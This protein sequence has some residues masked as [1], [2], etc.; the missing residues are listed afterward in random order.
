VFLVV[1]AMVGAFTLI[2]L[3]AA[4]VRQIN[5]KDRERYEAFLADII[6][7][8]PDPFDSA[9]RVPMQNVPQL[10]NICLWAITQ[11]ENKTPT[12]IPMDD[13]GY[14][15]VPED[16]VE[17]TYKRIFGASPPSHRTVEGSDFDF[18]YDA[19]GKCYRVPM[20]GSLAIYAPRVTGTKKTGSSIE[21]TV[22]YLAY[23][24]FTLDARGRPAEPEASKVML[25]TLYEQAD[26]SLQVGSIRQLTGVGY[27]PGA[28]QIG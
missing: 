5:A 3:A 8:D 20:T 2:R 7:H 19:A 18:L 16:M 27:A 11:T 26:G 9:D 6:V 4:G 25:I 13:E 24:D 15:L 22:D 17:E 28:T 12:E 21:L 14:L 23:S 1:L 10:L